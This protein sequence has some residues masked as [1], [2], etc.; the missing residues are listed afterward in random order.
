MHI[1]PNWQS[2]QIIL[3]RIACGFFIVAVL[4]LGFT[5]NEM[6][7]QQCGR[8]NLFWV[9]LCY[10]LGFVLYG[11]MCAVMAAVIQQPQKPALLIRSL[12]VVG[13]LAWLGATAVLYRGFSRQSLE[14]QRKQS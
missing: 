7:R 4:L 5:V 12:Q 14:E 6:R 3:N 10:M 8:P 13:T 11:A 1:D 2:D 9:L